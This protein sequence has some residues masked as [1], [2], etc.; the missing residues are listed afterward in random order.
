VLLDKC[1]HLIIDHVDVR[2]FDEALDLIEFLGREII[3]AGHPR[4]S[5]SEIECHDYLASSADRSEKRNKLVE[6]GNPDT[7]AIK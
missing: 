6:R 3:E 2:P 1:A 5:A 7:L 4:L